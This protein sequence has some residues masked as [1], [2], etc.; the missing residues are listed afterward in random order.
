M[1]GGVQ[2]LPDGDGKAIE[3]KNLCKIYRIYQSPVQRLKEI[4]TGK[5]LHTDFIA[6]Q[7]IN[8]SVRKG[9]SFG[10]IG[11]NGAGKSTL[12]KM[13][14]RTLKPTSGE[15]SVHGRLAALL[16]LGAGFNPEL[17]GE[18]N[19]YLNAY[20]MGLTQKEVDRKKEEIIDFSELGDFI[21]R[22]VKTYSSGMHVRLAFSIATSIDPEILIIDEALSVGDQHFQK[23]CIDR[24]MQFRK[25]G[26]TIF[27]CSHSLYLVQ[28][29]CGRAVWLKNGKLEKIGSA[30]ETINAYNDWVRAKD[31]GFSVSDI[32]AGAID[33]AEDKKCWIA[34]ARIID[35]AGHDITVMNT[36]CDIWLKVVIRTSE[37]PG[38]IKGHIGIGLNRNDDEPVYGVTSKMDGIPP[39]SFYDGLEVSLKFPSLPLLSAQYYML[40]YLGDDH[41]LLPYDIYRSKMFS[42]ENFGGDLGLVRLNHEWRIDSKFSGG[43]Q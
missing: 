25:E 1:S 22:P 19:I 31:A 4:V 8:F 23:K 43:E 34:S 36:G 37:P 30:P 21:K 12:L 32:N 7:D 39:L 33:T 29:L 20:L 18:E 11:E 26:K 28:E 16:E 38:R 2:Y 14:S 35:E 15:L 27:F 13:L 42:V 9:E 6:L 5:K 41:A 40:V 24:M 10:I 3:A 17:T